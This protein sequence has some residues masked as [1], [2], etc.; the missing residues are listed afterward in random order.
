MSRV[1][2]V[3]NNSVRDLLARVR[4]GALAA[5]ACLV[6]FAASTTLARAAE[7]GQ[8]AAGL[9]PVLS[10]SGETVT[11]APVG[12]EL[13]Y[14]VAISTA[15]RSASPRVTTYL[16]IPREPGETQSYTLSLEPGKTAYVGVSADGDTWSANEAVVNAPSPP[17]P[18]PPPPPGLVLTVHGE[19]IS[20]SAIPGVT[21]YTLATVLNPGSSRNTTYTVVAGTSF[22]PP[23][24]PGQTVNYG[25]SATVP[26]TAPWAKEVSIAY[27]REETSESEGEGE[28]KGEGEGESPGEP[29]AGSESEPP[30]E[31]PAEPPAEQPTEPPAEQTGGKIIGVHDGAGWGAAAASTILAGHITWN[32][33]EIGNTSNTLASSLG[34]GF[35]VLAIVGNVSDGKPLSQIEPAH[36]GTEAADEILG[37]PGMAIA[38]AGNEMYYKGGVANPVQYGRMYLAA[39]VAMKAAG[40]R[41][42][43]LFNMWGDY[44]KGSNSSPT[45]WSQDANGGGWLRDAVNGVPGLAAAILANGLSTHPYGALGENSADEQGVKA[46]AA[47]ESVAKTVLGATPPIYI[48]EFGYAMSRCGAPDGACSQL[49]QATKMGAAY[50]ALLSDP[51]VAGIWWYESHDDSNGSFGFMNNDNTTR[52]SFSVLSSIARQQGQ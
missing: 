52:P 46:V 6:A 21:R 38:E 12:A 11:W 7:T 1:F 35:K 25:L 39:V 24:V 45:G 48:T 41:I 36:W 34:Y 16:D 18:P 19:T 40:I 30:A 15:P 37:N 5:G 17:S 8:L 50:E 44:P 2:N 31:E 27:P 4:V 9:T 26:G 51:H 43:L 14:R 20:W 42:P 29:P 10:V 33:V 28:S 49:E 32:R 47:Q 22:T 3:S 23:A 13:T